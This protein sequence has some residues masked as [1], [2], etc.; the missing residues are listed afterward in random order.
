MVET[1]SDGRAR[2]RAGQDRG[3]RVRPNRGA[4]PA[5]GIA[6]LKTGPR[7]RP[8]LTPGNWHPKSGVN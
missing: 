7:Y 2:H 8:V 5:T 3:G 4:V 6:H 1:G